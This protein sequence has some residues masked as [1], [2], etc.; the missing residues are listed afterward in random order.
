MPNPD[1]TDLTTRQ[2]AEAIALAV[3]TMSYDKQIGAQWE[4][5]DELAQAVMDTLDA[6]GC[7]FCRKTETPQGTRLTQMPLW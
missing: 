5:A 1:G 2:L 7:W 3:M 4:R 6:H